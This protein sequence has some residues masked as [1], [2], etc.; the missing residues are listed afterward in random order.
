MT[1]GNYCYKGTFI[2]RSGT[3]YKLNIYDCVHIHFR[4]Q[5]GQKAYPA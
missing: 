3:V 4:G 5:E 1:A 2:F